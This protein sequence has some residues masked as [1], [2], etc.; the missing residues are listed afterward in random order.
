MK[1][2]V[3]PAY[4]P[5]ENLEFADLPKPVPGP[6]QVL[7][8][9]QAAALNPVDKALVTGA[10]RNVVPVRHP[11]VPGV[12]I[13]G[14]VEAVG[15]GATRF[16][17]GDPVIAWNG[18]TSGALA[19]YAVVADAPSAARRPAELT[20]AQG[21][22]LPTG[23]L[24]AAALMD[25]ARVPDGGSVLVVGATGG[26]GTYAVQLARQAGLTVLATGRAGD[27]DFLRRLGAHHVL[28]HQAVDL[29]EEAHRL[30]PGGVDTVLDLAHAG[31]AL[32]T[33]AAAAREAGLVVSP[34]GGPP[35]FDRGV[36]ASY[37]GTVTPEGRLAD[38]AE[39]AAKGELRIEIESTYAF[40]DARQA[41]LDFAS[42][43]IR[44]KVAVTF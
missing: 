40:D 9:L 37:G 27:E 7:V 24:T 34:L 17:V 26:I 25:L 18:V 13:S 15:E 31:P 8:R 41:L 14:V 22:A 19:E 5:L 20:P 1:A 42:R 33:T 28:D 23:A 30:V 2:L 4:G 35:A 11:F 3:A 29:A 12:D 43:R 6:G 36:T 44:G 21:A 32:A 39:R 38:L 10:M 16:A